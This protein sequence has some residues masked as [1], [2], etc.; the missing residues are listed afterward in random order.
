MK[1]MMYVRRGLY[2][3]VVRNQADMKIWD[4]QASQLEALGK[5]QAIDDMQDILRRMIAYETNQSMQDE[6]TD[7]VS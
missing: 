4:E 5:Q 2:S 3:M 6:S 7:N 1:F